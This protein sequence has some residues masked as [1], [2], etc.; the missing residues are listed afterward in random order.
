M[1]KKPSAAAAGAAAEYDDDIAAR[2]VG[3]GR[4]PGRVG[5]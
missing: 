3:R 1:P 4:V 2:S 5:E